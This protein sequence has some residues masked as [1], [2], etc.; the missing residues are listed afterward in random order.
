[1][2]GGGGRERRDGMEDGVID[3]DIQVL[4]GGGIVVGTSV[5]E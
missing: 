4:S 1:M 5:W 3:D 2:S